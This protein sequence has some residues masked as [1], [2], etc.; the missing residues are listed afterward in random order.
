MTYHVLV[1]PP[2]HFATKLSPLGGIFQLDLAR[3]LKAKGYKVGV[4]SVGKYPIGSL[5]RTYQ[6]QKYEQFCGIPVIRKYMRLPIP[7]SC[8]P[9]LIAGRFIGGGAMSVLT[10]Y[11]ARHGR[12]DL[13]HAHN[14]RYSGIAAATVSARTGIPFVLTEH[15]SEFATGEI[16]H[17]A[18]N[19]CRSVLSS[20][21]GLS[22]VSNSLKHHVSRVAGCDYC[23]RTLVIPNLLPEQFQNSSLIRQGTIGGDFTFVNVAEALPIKNQELL[24]ASFAER[25]LHKRV[26]LQIVGDGERLGF[27]RRTA[28]ELKVSDQ[29]EFL[30]RLSRDDVKTTLRRADC[31]VLSSHHETFGVALIEA[32]SQGLPVIATACGGPNDIVDKT[33]GLLV[34]PD[35]KT[36]LSAAMQEMYTAKNKYDTRLIAAKCL[37]KYGTDAVIS[38]YIQLYDLALAA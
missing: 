1:I 4:A 29:V 19:V 11:I 5:F 27:L 33:N 25:F 36:A 21:K 2:G 14:M 22:V 30:G 32:M 28:S 38:R 17:R 34:P 35:D 12:P 31:F 23:D 24:I 8:D 16:S 13:I 15:S 26:K 6:Y 7:A 10:E 20:A 37:E 18:R 3:A 9:W